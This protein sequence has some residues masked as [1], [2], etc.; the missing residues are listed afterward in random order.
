[1]TIL[2]REAL[3]NGNT[4][5]RLIENKIPSRVGAQDASVYAFSPEARA[6]AEN[7]M[8][9]AT[10]ASLPPRDPA[11]IAVLAQQ[12]RCE[13]L[14]AVVLIGQGGST[15][16]PQTIT[17]LHSLEVTDEIPFRTMDSISPVYVNHILGSSDPART[18]Y[19][20]SSKSGSTLEPTVL[21]NVA[22]SYVCAHL[23]ADRAGRRFVAITDP[24]S[25]LEQVAMRDGWRAVIHGEPNVGG[26]YSAL[27]VF[28]LMP[29]A[30]VGIDVEGVL[31]RAA[32]TER[33]C[34]SDSPDNPALQLACFLYDN[35]CQGR[36]KFSLLMPPQSQ[37]FGLWVEQ[38]VAES[39]GKR[40]VGILPNIE[41]DAGILSDPLPDRCVILCNSG[42]DRAYE[43]ARTCLHPSI[44]AMRLDIIDSDDIAE[45]FLIWEYA[46]AFC[47]WLMRVDPFDQP[48]VES[49]KKAVKQILYGDGG[50]Y[51][52]PLDPQGNPAYV[53]YPCAEGTIVDSV[54]VSSALLG[55]MNRTDKVD[56][57][58][59]LRTLFYS[60]GEGDYFSLNA[61]L[62][63]KG[64]G[65]RETLERIRHRVAD[66]LQAC[67]CLEIGPRYLHST[68]QLHKG[69]PDNGVFLV[70]SSREAY[71]M[72]VP[73]EGF[74]LGE[75]ANAQALGDF[76]AL[77][78]RGRRAVYVRL[79]DND[80]EY[81]QLLADA[82]CSAVSAT[83]AFRRN[84]E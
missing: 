59:A 60:I 80:S 52:V 75:V 55:R 68:G 67:S 81:L 48:D 30:C 12:A 49:T 9:W 28:G 27:S 77:A 2:D 65:R 11:E 57:A 32:Q 6:T 7:R 66:R 1:M 62:P 40:G 36:D 15:Q 33:L 25:Q 82:A 23:G 73:H 53:E 41:V 39:L 70:V 63:F 4:A 44:P 51:E 45:H 64:I 74:T 79:K 54:F 78:S 22:W 38:L 10:L 21:S 20:V 69:G 14:D 24:G 76:G 50:A 42:N 46:V 71:D 26:R 18:L 61:F 84:G 56:L 72:M 37:V 83:Y 43:H 17:K 31:S 34:A 5:R 58:R 47:G 29:M 8:G 19:I 16:A 13:G 3:G 35:Y